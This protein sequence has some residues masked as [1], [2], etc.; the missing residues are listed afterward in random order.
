MFKRRR[1]IFVFS[2]TKY[3]SMSSFLTSTSASVRTPL[4]PVRAGRFFLLFF[5]HV[6]DVVDIFLP[7][8][9]EESVR[10]MRVLLVMEIA[11]VGGVTER[12]VN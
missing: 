2:A 10:I 1:A 11:R 7:L 5:Y 8:M 9:C 4:V 12:H 3:A 6:N